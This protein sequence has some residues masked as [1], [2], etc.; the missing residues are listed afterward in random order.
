MTSQLVA[1]V[2]DLWAERGL[3]SQIRV[4]MPAEH[5]ALVDATKIPTYTNG[6]G[7]QKAKVTVVS[8]DRKPD[9]NGT[10]LLWYYEKS[11]GTLL[12]RCNP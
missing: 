1:T 3:T 7:N 5:A 9:T 6:G 4:R 2:N 12:H 10:H 11:D 8:E